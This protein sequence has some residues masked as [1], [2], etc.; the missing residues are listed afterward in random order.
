MAKTMPVRLL[1]ARSGQ[2]ALEIYGLAQDVQEPN[3]VRFLDHI[4]QRRPRGSGNTEYA[5]LLMLALS[6]K[7]SDKSNDGT[8]SWAEQRMMDDFQQ[9]GYSMQTLLNMRDGIYK[10]G[11]IVQPGAET[12]SARA[13]QQAAVKYIAQNGTDGDDAGYCPCGESNDTPEEQNV[14]GNRFSSGHGTNE[15][16]VPAV[17]SVK[18]G[19]D[20]DIMYFDDDDFFDDFFW[21]L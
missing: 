9:L 20:Y 10:H 15:W 19:L 7:Y 11:N 18:R 5:N 12:E 13:A 1:G 8:G 2:Q 17:S 3:F 4:I 21:G 14:L 6:G 16:Q